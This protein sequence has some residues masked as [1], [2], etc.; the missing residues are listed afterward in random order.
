ML[1]STGCGIPGVMA[2]RT[3]ENEHD[4]RMTVMTTTFMP[5]GAKLPIIALISGAILNGAWW[6]AP[7]A[8]FLGIF[9]VIVSGIILKKTRM[10]AGDPSPFVMELPAYHLPT[11]TNILR[12]MW[13]RAWSFIRKAGTVILISAVTVWFLSGFGFTGGK[14]GMVKDLDDGLLAL[15]GGAIAWIFSPLGFGTWDAAAAVITGLVAKENVVGTMGVLYGFAEVTEDGSEIWD[16]FAAHFTVFSAYAFLAFNL[17]CAPC[18][19]AI[20]AIRRE[21]NNAKWTWFALGYQTVYAY[22][23]ALVIYQLGALFSG[24]GFGAGTVSAFAVLALFIYLLV[25]KPGRKARIRPDKTAGS[26]A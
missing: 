18:F 26:A 2:S 21:M 5:C 19:A 3:I 17:L 15:I 14:F 8:Y 16:A 6:V 25:R 1:I 4:R 9:S 24:G 20:G 11:I 7:S 22:G 12:S 10:F 13:E 23:A